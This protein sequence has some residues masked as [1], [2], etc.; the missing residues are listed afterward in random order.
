[1]R[2]LRDLIRRGLDHTAALWPDVRET[3]RWLR[4]AAHILGNARNLPAAAVEAR[5]DRL[6]NAWTA[7]RAK[8]GSLAPAVDHFLKVTVSYRP[9]LFHCYAVPGLP[10]TNNDLEHLFGSHRYHE[11]RATGRKVA[12]PSL[13]LRGSVRI[14]AAA[15]TRIAPFTDQE[16]A[17][18]DRQHWRRLRTDLERRRQARVCR[19]RFRRQPNAYLASLERLA[20]QQ[21]LPS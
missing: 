11:R 1:M 9:G 10:R 15:A 8:A 21:G 13:V 6:I 12:S 4:A 5:Y 17:A 20:Q 19:S 14:L 16:L 3:H 18:A 2:R 7:R